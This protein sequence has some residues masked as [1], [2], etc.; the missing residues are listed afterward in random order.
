MKERVSSY[1]GD[2]E[3]GAGIHDGWRVH[4]AMAFEDESPVVEER[5]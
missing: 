1:G 2:C 3:A 4:A 5:R